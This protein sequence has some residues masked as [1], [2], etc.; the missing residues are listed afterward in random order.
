VGIRMNEIVL[1]DQYLESLTTNV[2][3]IRDYGFIK[4]AGDNLRGISR[5]G[6][7]CNWGPRVRAVVEQL[8]GS[9]ISLPAEDLV[10]IKRVLGVE[11]RNFLAYRKTAN[12]AERKVL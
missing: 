4:E 12:G 2:D 1:S 5:K 6:C 11:G 9:F 3:L 7:Q 8:R 10:K